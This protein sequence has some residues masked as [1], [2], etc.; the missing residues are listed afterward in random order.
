MGKKITLKTGCILGSHWTWQLLSKLAITLCML[1][2]TILMSLCMSWGEIKLSLLLYPKTLITSV[3]FNVCGISSAQLGRKTQLV[4]KIAALTML[5]LMF[6]L[7]SLF[8]FDLYFSHS[9]LV[10]CLFS[11]YYI[12]SNIIL[13]YINN[14]L[15][16]MF[17]YFIYFEFYYI[18]SHFLIHV[19]L[20][21]FF[22]P[23][24]ISLISFIL[25]LL[26]LFTYDYWCIFF[27]SFHILWLLFC[28][29]KYYFFHL[30]VCS[31]QYTSHHLFIIFNF[32]FVS[33]MY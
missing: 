26:I 8:W 14:L 5:L 25:L 28:L 19:F 23:L 21:L 4:M 2:L 22:I 3:K 12:F 7:F 30:H 24:L 6:L 33:F 27:I 32:V 29:F 13:I 20:Y 10:I 11:P 1:F 16:S 18:Q 15:V 17:L 31:Q 9:F